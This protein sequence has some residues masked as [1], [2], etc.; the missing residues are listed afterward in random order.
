[1]L[2]GPVTVLRSDRIRTDDENKDV[3]TLDLLV[4]IGDPFGILDKITG[5]RHY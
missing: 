1:V 5:K 3:V 4:D 2:D